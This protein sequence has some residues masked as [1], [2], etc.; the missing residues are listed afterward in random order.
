LPRCALLTI[1]S[2]EG[3][4]ADDELLVLPL[5]KRGWQVDFVPWDSPTA[6]WDDYDI[7]VIRSTWDYYRRWEEYLE[8]LTRIEASGA[9][10]H[11]PLDVVRWNI[12]KR[13]L[14]D[15]EARGVTI[16]PT[17]WQ[18]PFDPASLPEVRTQL[19]SDDLIVKPNVSAGADATYRLAPSM[20]DDP[21]ADIAHELGTRRVM[22]QPMVASVVE[23]G[24]YSLFYLGGEYSHAILKTPKAHD[25]RVQ[26][27]YGSSIV[28]VTPE[29]DLASTAAQVMA[30]VDRPLLY[31]RVDLVR[32]ADGTP[33]VMELELIEP[34]LYLRYDEGAAER[35]A[36]AIHSR[37]DPK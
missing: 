24:E 13:Y 32:L 10:L 34:S 1:A 31:A 12:D 11:N 27:E 4:V 6:C 5:E 33:A 26:E 14:A 17:V 19:G 16:V 28:P 37:L 8:V 35:L 21:L 30:A 36:D 9:E 2:L 20:T 15:L 7:V 29:A 3:F 22:L 18:S 23:V 25:F